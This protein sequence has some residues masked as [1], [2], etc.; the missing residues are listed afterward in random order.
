MRPKSINLGISSVAFA[1]VAAAPAS[2]QFEDKTCLVH[3]SQFSAVIRKA[4]L[5]LDFQEVIS[6]AS[7]TSFITD[8]K[9]KQWDLIGIERAHAKIVNKAEIL[10]L[11]K[12]QHAGGAKFIV[13]YA[14]LDE[15]PELQEFLG[16][17]NAVDVPQVMEVKAPGSGNRIWS[18]GGLGGPMPIWS[19][20]GD[21]LSPQSETHVTTEF[22]S[23]PLAGAV[24]GTLSSDRTKL[25]CGFNLDEYQSTPVFQLE[26][27][28]LALLLCDADVDENGVVDIQDFLMLQ[29]YVSAA[30]PF[31][32]RNYDEFIN[33]FD[34]L[35]FINSF[36]TNCVP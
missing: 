11:F 27:H 14:H 9:A 15:W 28:I 23:G 29:T 35:D 2:A 25:C 3:D 12:Q 31:G 36:D 24:A 13:S 19:D 16:L 6:W 18:T 30:F 17:V 33:F 20:H 7:E 4:A 5:Q 22:V 34:F 21:A 10:D 32:N 26:R 8:L 1:I